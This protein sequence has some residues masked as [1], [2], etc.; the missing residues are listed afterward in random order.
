MGGVRFGL[1]AEDGSFTAGLNMPRQYVGSFNITIT[2]QPNGDAAF[3]LENARLS[4]PRSIKS[5]VCNR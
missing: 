4:M 3:V 2:E 1:D 5:R